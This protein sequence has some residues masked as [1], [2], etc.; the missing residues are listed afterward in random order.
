MT[1]T[2]CN[3]KT[4]KAE[5]KAYHHT[6]DIVNEGSEANGSHSHEVKY[7]DIESPYRCTRLVN[8]QATP[9]DISLPIVKTRGG[10]DGLLIEAAE[11]H[12]P[13]D[14]E[15]AHRV[16]EVSGPHDAANNLCQWPTQEAISTEDS[17]TLL[18]SLYAAAAL[19]PHICAG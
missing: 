7:E 4:H 16:P 19:T 1:Q 10:E 3:N 18:H 15:L 11:A 17:R 13:E 14:W 8:Y 6:L 2:T 9:K 5:L 12:C